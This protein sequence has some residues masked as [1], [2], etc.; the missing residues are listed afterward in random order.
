MNLKAK[1][2]VDN[3][4]KAAENK[5]VTRMAFLNEKVMDG[6]AIQ[7]DARI[8][9]IRAEIRKA[10]FRMSCIAAQEKLND[11]KAQ[12]KAEKLAAKKNAP[13]GSSAK[14]IKGVSRK[15][16]KKEKKK[17]EKAG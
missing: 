3:Q 5:L 17:K 16:V 10:N 1:I 2:H 14:T 11:E 7:Q 13:E 12:T 6:P 15:T 8:R 9:K 4:R